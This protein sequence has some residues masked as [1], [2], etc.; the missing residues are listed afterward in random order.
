MS[1][2]SIWSIVAALAAAAMFAVAAVAQHRA[3]AAVPTGDSLVATLV[4]SPR[5]LVGVV[6]DGVGYGWQVLALALGPV[7]I[8]Q[9]LLVTSLVFA[10]PLAA[11]I[12]GRRVDGRSW[13]CAVLLVVALAAFLIVGAP[14]S[15]NPTAPLRHWLIPLAVLLGVVVLAVLLADTRGA[16][17]RGARAALLFG[18]AGGVLFGLAAALTNFVAGR[19]TD[20]LDA[21]VS[22]WQTWALVAAAIIGFYLQ[23][24]A[25]Q[26]GS[27]SAALPA[28]T[29]AEPL[30]AAFLG[31]TVLEESLRTDG[32]A[33]VVVPLSVI[34]LCATTIALAHAEAGD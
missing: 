13:L 28:T 15:G 23:Q 30:A 4:R 26:A 14:T 22:S 19:F 18:T 21:V 34:V 16:G 32:F 2:H 10:L 7:L 33:L 24:R 3:A 6:T 25:Y 20:G 1:D 29:V 5:W 17:P 9:P 27:L 31:L 8:V 11:R 12:D